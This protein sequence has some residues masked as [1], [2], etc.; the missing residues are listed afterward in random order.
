MY[1]EGQVPR[2][3]MT[4][5]MILEVWSNVC[6]K[7]LVLQKFKKIIVFFTKIWP[8]HKKTS[9][10]GSIVTQGTEFMIKFSSLCK[11]LVKQVVFAKAILMFCPASTKK[12]FPKE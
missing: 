7:I 3:K 6:L 4:W 2:V 1:T 9:S 11:Y 10:K 5:N 12:V 8:N